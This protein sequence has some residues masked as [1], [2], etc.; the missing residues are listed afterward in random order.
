MDATIKL[1]KTT[2]T[3]DELGYPAETETA[4]EAFCSVGSVTRSEFFQAGK[5]GIVPDYVFSV[6]AIEYEGEKELEYNGDKFGIYRTYKADGSDYIELYAEY[7]SGV[8]DAAEP[9]P[10]PPTPE[11]DPEPE[12]GPDPEEETEEPDA[13]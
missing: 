10:E 9:E 11:P 8:T 3:Q 5:A 6:N 4:R 7:K 1:I 12:P 13:G 2:T